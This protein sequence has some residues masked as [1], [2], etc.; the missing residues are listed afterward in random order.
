MYNFNI[1]IRCEG[2]NQVMNEQNAKMKKPG[3]IGHMSFG[4]KE[5]PLQWKRQEVRTR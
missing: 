5:T 2:R 4:I 3:T 1:K